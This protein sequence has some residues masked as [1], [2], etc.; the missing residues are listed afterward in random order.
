MHI[1]NMSY[2]PPTGTHDHCA[3][4]L[5]SVFSPWIGTSGY[6]SWH[7]GLLLISHTC[8]PS[9]VIWLSN[10]DSKFK[11]WLELINVKETCG[12]VMETLS[13]VRCVITNWEL[14]WCVEFVSIVNTRV[15]PDLNGTSSILM[16]DPVLWA[17]A[18]IEILWISPEDV[19]NNKP[20]SDM[21]VPTISTMNTGIQHQEQPKQGFHSIKRREAEEKNAREEECYLLYSVRYNIP[22]CVQHCVLL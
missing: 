1:A 7:S 10:V 2:R 6:I 3:R 8:F 13:Y 17:P 20:N 18:T 4:V 21:Y 12:V 14:E 9:V 22:G 19:C 16:D 11:K 15:D 5:T